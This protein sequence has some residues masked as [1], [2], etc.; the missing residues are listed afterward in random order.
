VLF[1]PPCCLTCCSHLYGRTDAILLADGHRGRQLL[2]PLHCVHRDE[3]S[4]QQQVWQRCPRPT[5]CR[6]VRQPQLLLKEYVCRKDS[7]FTAARF[8]QRRLSHATLFRP[9]SLV[10]MPT[11]NNQ[12]QVGGARDIMTLWCDTLDYYF[13]LACKCALLH[14][15]CALYE[16]AA[17]PHSRQ[18]DYTQQPGHTHGS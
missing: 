13:V 11:V 5:R 18:L 1:S 8:T 2:V 7:F 12:L 3:R 10:K 4:V 17:C 9:T 15:S 16:L 14:G 6:T